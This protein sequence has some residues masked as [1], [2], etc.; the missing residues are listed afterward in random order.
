MRSKVAQRILDETPEEVKVYVAKYADLVV[1][2]NESI[3]KSGNE[4]NLNTQ[5]LKKELLELIEF[6]KK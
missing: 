2:I 6:R 4:N 1:K 3:R 5:S